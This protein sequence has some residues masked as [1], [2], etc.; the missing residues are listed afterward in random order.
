MY[1]ERI[2]QHVRNG[3]G[4][5]DPKEVNG[6]QILM[7]YNI[8]SPKDKARYQTNYERSIRTK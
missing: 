8:T 3:V 2:L 7:R 5:I 4:G 6:A 1:I